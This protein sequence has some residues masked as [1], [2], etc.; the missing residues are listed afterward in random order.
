VVVWSDGLGSL[1]PHELLGLVQHV[2]W[3]GDKLELWDNSLVGN[4]SS[5]V[6]E[7]VLWLNLSSDDDHLL[8][9]LV[10]VEVQ[11]WS[12]WTGKGLDSLEGLGLLVLEQL[13]GPLL[14]WVLV[15]LPPSEKGLVLVG[16]VSGG[17]AFLGLVGDLSLVGSHPFLIDG[18]SELS[19]DGK[20]SSLE[21]ILLDLGVSVGDGEASVGVES[22]RV[23]SLVD[24]PDGSPVIDI[25]GDLKSGVWTTL[26]L[27]DV[28]LSV[29]WETGLNEEW[30]LPWLAL[31]LLLWDLEEPLPMLGWVLVAVPP[32][33]EVLIL[34]LVVLGGEALLGLVEDGEN[35]LLGAFLDLKV[36]L[37][38]G[39]GVLS[40]G[41]GLADVESVV[42]VSV[43]ESERS[44]GIESNGLGSGIHDEPGS[45][46]VD[47]SLELADFVWSVLLGAHVD[48]SVALHVELEVELLAPLWLSEWLGELLL[49]L[50]GSSG[51]DF[52]NSWLSGLS[53][54][55]LDGHSHD[56]EV[57]EWSLS[58]SLPGQWGVWSEVNVSKAELSPLV[59]LSLDLASEP[60]VL[61]GELVLEES[62][63]GWGS[64]L[65]R[66]ELEGEG[67]V[68]LMEQSERLRSL[69]PEPSLEW[70]LGVEGLVDDDLLVRQSSDD[71]GVS[72][73][74]LWSVG[75]SD[76]ENVSFS[77]VDL[78]RLV[79]NNSL[80]SVVSESLEADELD[81]ESLELRLSAWQPGQW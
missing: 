17:E 55:L 81:R 45:P 6:G 48:S 3:L 57:L 47:S 34:V 73:G 11:S 42:A 61:L 37:I 27:A 64:V 43:G 67:E 9:N 39:S 71:L 49:D 28:D 35:S 24:D 68:S 74:V 54:L 31:E 8:V 62:D 50:V 1:L 4:D 12:S 40:E 79:K 36:V 33:E 14:G 75:S 60:L 63:T 7:R 26:L 20:L 69:V 25:L 65:L 80:L 38:D 52:L 66:L 78:E 46:V 2:E 32:H 77:L 51:D 19:D 58:A 29:S 76:V 72:D 18:S 59:E 30:D 5:E 53:H 21:S 22:D 16:V 10:K 70:V 56:V 13:D 23:G 44:V 41:N 15:A